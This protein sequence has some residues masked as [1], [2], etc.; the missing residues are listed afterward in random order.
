MQDEAGSQQAK[1]CNP[2]SYTLVFSVLCPTYPHAMQDTHTHNID[3]RS[4]AELEATHSLHAAAVTRGLKPVNSVS[5]APTHSNRLLAFALFALAGGLHGCATK[6]VKYP[7]T[8]APNT[9]SATQGRTIAS[10]RLALLARAGELDSTPVVVRETSAIEGIEIAALPPGLDAATITPFQMNELGSDSPRMLTLFAVVKSLLAKT[11]IDAE[12]QPVN[13]DA[14]PNAEP[15]AKPNLNAV[16]PA[17][18]A[19]VQE[20][21]KTDA[22]RLYTSG[23]LA[24]KAKDAEQAATDLESAA[25]LDPN[26]PEIWRSLGEAQIAL[27]RRASGLAS[28]RKAA[29]L[30]LREPGMLFT[31]AREAR[32]SNKHDQAATIYAQILHDASLINAEADSNAGRGIFIDKTVIDKAVID[33]GLAMLCFLD[34]AGA[35]DALG[36][37]SASL[38]SLMNGLEISLNQVS[39]TRYRD[40]ASEAVR[41]RSSQWM[42]GGDLAMRLNNAGV[43]R[44]MYDQAAR[45]TMLDPAPLLAR[46]VHAALQAGNPA[47]AAIAVVDDITRM[48]GRVDERQIDLIAFLV[49]QPT[50]RQ[51]GIG[52]LLANCIGIDTDATIAPSTE[53]TPAIEATRTIRVR[54]ALAQAAAY[55]A[56]PSNEPARNALRRLLAEDPLDGDLLLALTQMHDENSSTTDRAA[57]AYAIVD[58]APLAAFVAAN[59]LL[60]DGRVAADVAS[61]PASMNIGEALVQAALLTRVGKGSVALERIRT[62]VEVNPSHPAVLSIA[63]QIAST[64]GAWSDMA[65]WL[66]ALEPLQGIGALRSKVAAYMAAQ[67]SDDARSASFELLA[68]VLSLA[69]VSSHASSSMSTP[70][71]QASVTEQYPLT[72]SDMLLGAQLALVASNKSEAERLVTAAIKLDRFDERGYEAAFQFYGPLSPATN[73][74]MVS[75]TGATLRQMIPGSR[76]I[77]LVST[78]E[79]ASRSLWKQ[80]AEQAEQLLE[81]NIESPNVL[82]MYATAIERSAA[83]NP[84]VAEVAESNLQARHKARAQSPLLTI[85]LARVLAARDKGDEADTLLE[86]SYGKLAIPELARAR[87]RLLRYTLA[88]PQAADALTRA[89]LDAAPKNIENTLELAEFHKEQNQYATAATTLR[90]NLPTTVRL[91]RAHASRLVQLVAGFTQESITKNSPST[92]AGILDLLDAVAS[93]DE[94]RLPEQLDA[95]RV[96]LL[97][98]TVPEDTRRLLDACKEFVK[99][100]PARALPTYG[101]IAEALLTRDNPAAALAFLRGASSEINPP[102]DLI[103]FETYRLT[104]LR[105]TRDDHLALPIEINEP[106]R[107]A[108]LVTTITG[109]KPPSMEP[110]RL[111]AEIYYLIGN[112]LS[113]I[114]KVDDGHALYDAAL[115]LE[116]MHPWVNN[117]YGYALLTKGGD[118]ERARSMIEIAFA[119]KPNEPSIIDS[120]GWV[121]YMEN[122]LVTKY[123]ADGTIIE[124]GALDLLAVAANLAD[125]DSATEVYCHLG[126]ALWR[127]GQNAQALI[128]WNTAFK[129]GKAR[130]RELDSLRKLRGQQQQE[131]EDPAI[132]SR[133]EI[134]L[135]TLTQRLEAKINAASQGKKPPVAEQI[136]LK[137]LLVPKA[138]PEVVPGMP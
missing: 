105:G 7:D 39:T 98:Q 20:D 135:T 19:D 8:L 128:H 101:T 27:G 119:S 50:S 102:S 114:N 109:N 46:R 40:E 61:R 3:A 112:A 66:D 6:I 53:T 79:L 28:L 131:E 65:R 138:V 56:E 57:D 45:G 21:E 117:N 97:A 31:L 111:R 99:R 49:Q 74:A 75:Q 5:R 108:M 30:G 37:S 12:P 11:N 35:L 118:F 123:N 94:V 129:A 133:F 88:K 125:E 44:K 41:Y 110:A 60:A 107:I 34:L 36:Y 124:R 137:P 64:Q 100:H 83:T 14:N 17:A 130:L 95:A 72:V 89:R 121:R 33:P 18:Q 91:T 126:D 32:R 69:E 13:I 134:E 38:E 71:G 127:A 76:F 55:S 59:V 52:P 1:L 16:A 73:Q 93:R 26:A 92:A 96:A 42:A 120:M 84:A 136:G 116:P 47:R 63:I 122:R 58:Q 25:R 70:A 15:N 80:V 106:I 62:I 24:L 68:P 51:A 2:P 10:A 77:R 78:Q 22:F 9:N 113:S 29:T 132:E 81:P 54:L 82:D 86:R 90:E 87:E 104:V 23:R 4:H 67:R 103:L 48:R 43:A 115:T 85:A